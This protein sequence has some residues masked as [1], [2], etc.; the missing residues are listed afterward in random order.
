LGPN[1]VA[2]NGR[3]GLFQFNEA[4]WTASGTDIP[5]D[6]GSAAMDPQTAADVALALLYRKLGYGG[7]QNPTPSAIQQAI[8]NFGEGDGR[9]GQAVM[10][11][12]RQLQA[13]DFT[14]AYGTLQSYA[15]WVAAGRP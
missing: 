9:Y 11:C 10:D 5:W 2:A 6:S 4:S 8:D 3:V 12:A 15:S 14:G 1:V 13:G 7:T